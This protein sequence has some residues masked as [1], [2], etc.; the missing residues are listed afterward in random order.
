V[1]GEEK[2]YRRGVSQAEYAKF[3]KHLQEMPDNGVKVG[4]VV[5]DY[6]NREDV[7]DAFNIPHDVQAWESC[8]NILEYHTQN[9]ASQW[10]YG[11]LKNQTKLMFYS[12]DSDGAVPTYG[13]KLWIK[14]L[15]W[16]VEEAWRP[17]YTNGQVSGYI[18]KFD[19]LDFITVKG[20]GHMAP[21]WKRQEVTEMISAYIHNE[22]I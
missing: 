11:V 9:E 22:A 15:N 19:G 18:E 13:S 14:E 20:T 10:I 5:A 21:Q 2:T 1:N 7:R 6:M 17:W 3:A 8:S 12:G 16:K 4:D